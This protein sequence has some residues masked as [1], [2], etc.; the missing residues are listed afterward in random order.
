MDAQPIFHSASADEWRRAV[1]KGRAAKPANEGDREALG[2]GMGQGDSTIDK[3]LRGMGQSEHA[4]RSYIFFLQVNQHQGGDNGG[5]HVG[6]QADDGGRVDSG[7]H[8]HSLDW[9]VVVV[10]AGADGLIADAQPIGL[11]SSL[12]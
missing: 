7:G 10:K 2:P 3:G 1:E 12:R 5:I 9:L 11:A 8:G 4:R 6:P